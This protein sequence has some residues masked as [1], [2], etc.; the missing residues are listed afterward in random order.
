MKI[1]EELLILAREHHLSLSLGNKAVN[2]AKSKNIANIKVLC[3]EIAQTFGSSFQAHFETEEVTIF[4]PLKQKSATLNILCEQ[5]TKE[6]QQLYQM[7]IALKDKHE[8]LAEFGTLLKAHTRAE[9]RD[10]FP[11]INLL[12][13]AQRQAI[14][15]SSEKHLPVTKL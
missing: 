8:L 9:D 13:K 1:A 7:A 6:H 3:L 12:S 5:L 15:T 4:A 11:N 10:L 2:T 14:K